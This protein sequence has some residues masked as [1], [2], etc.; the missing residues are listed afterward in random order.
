MKKT[1]ILIMLLMILVAT[2]VVAKEG[3]F[4]GAYLLPSVDISGD[5]GSGLDSGSGYGFKAGLGFNKYICIEGVLE[6]SNFDVKGGGDS[7][8][9]DGIAV[10][11]RVNFPLTTLDSAKIMSFEP[12]VL[13]GYGMY[14]AKSG[15]QSNSGNG[16]RLGIGI[17]QYLFRELSINLGYTSTDVTFDTNPERDGTIRELELGLIYHFL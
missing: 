12:Y 6:R 2:P 10:D 15:G 17:E 8:K 16:V 5:A 13:I 7:L 4:I 3:L 11:L 14:D 1:W 9:M